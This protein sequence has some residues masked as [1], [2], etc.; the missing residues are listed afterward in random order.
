[1]SFKESLRQMYNEGIHDSLFHSEM[2]AEFDYLDKDGM[3][4]VILQVL[5]KAVYVALH[6]SIFGI[7]FPRPYHSSLIISYPFF[8]C[9]VGFGLPSVS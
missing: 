2:K 1:M 8:L 9:G 4:L 6:L 5:W 3:G 7:A